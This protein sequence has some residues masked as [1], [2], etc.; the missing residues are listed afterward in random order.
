MKKWMFVFLLCVVTVNLKAQNVST[1]LFA[2]RDT[3]KLYLDVYTPATSS[4]ACIVYVFGGGFMVGTRNAGSLQEYYR[5]LQEQGFMVVAF[6]YRLGLKGKKIN[7]LS[8]QPI[9]QAIMMAVEDLYAAV[10]YLIEHSRE[11]KVDTSK[12]VLIGS[13]AGAITAL[14]ADYMLAR[15]MPVSQVLPENFRFA[16]VI[17]FAGAIFSREG[18]VNY[19]RQPA[20][21]FFLHGM[22]DKLV[23]YNKVQVFNLGMF[24]SKALVK[25][26]KKF[27]YPFYAYRYQNYGHEIAAVI[28]IELAATV[29][30][31]DNMVL[32]RQFR[33]KDAVINNP[34][35][36]KWNVGRI[37][38]SRLHKLQE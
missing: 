14:Q 30:F 7:T 13:S 36:P 5:H 9:E 27:N 23:P 8:V 18:R 34:S 28:E 12:I 38:P 3:Q 20:P 33:Q 25:R 35:I 17:S 1:F 32:S 15:R 21:T 4:K 24:G 31:I 19:L 6:D 11:L 16:G 10:Q 2:E 29:D 26:F 37:V 22:D